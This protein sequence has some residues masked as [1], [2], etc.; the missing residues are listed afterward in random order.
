VLEEE[1]HVWRGALDRAASRSALRQVLTHYTDEGSAAIELRIGA[2]G[3]PAL[4]DPAASLRFN[5]SHSAGMFLVALTRGHEVGVDIESI[6]PRRELL[7]LSERALDPVGAA[8]VRAARA[9]ERLR[10]FHAAWTRHE[11]IV[12]CHGVGLHRAMPPEPVTV[13]PLDVG[14]G[15]AAALAI[16]GEEMPPLKLFALGAEPRH[17][18]DLPHLA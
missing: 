11:A 15:F 12:K 16:G 6:R 10:V 5:L 9:G 17:S 8:A 4:A 14:P 13:T 2:Y 1:V 7:R 3:K 18:S